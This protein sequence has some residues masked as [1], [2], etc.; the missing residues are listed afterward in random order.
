MATPPDFTAG[1]VLTAAQMNAVGLWRVTSCTAT[2]A[3]GT[4]GSVSNGVVTIGTNNTAITVSN[5]FSADFDEYL[6]TIVGGVGS[7]TSRFNMTL[8]STAT[9]Y[10]S[11]IN[12]GFYATNTNGAV[13]GG[14]TNVPFAATYDVN[15]IHM[16][17]TVSNPFASKY[18]IFSGQFVNVDAQG[19]VGGILKNTTSYTAFTL[20]C[21]AGNVTGGKLRVYGYRL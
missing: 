16:N 7:T 8:G 9:G 12:Y 17:L 14:T 2:F 10:E 21:N 15:R 3:G 19:T 6:I 18:T 5:A 13:G 1:Q 20:T 4:A 11:S